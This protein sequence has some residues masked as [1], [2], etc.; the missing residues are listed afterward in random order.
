MAVFSRDGRRIVTAGRDYT[1]RVWDAGTGE[2]IASLE[3]HDGLVACANFSPDGELVVTASEDGKAMV[4]DAGSGKLL[5]VL[6][7]HLSDVRWAEFS[8]DGTL[9][10]TASEDCTARIWDVHPETR[11]P[12]EIAELVSRWV[13]WRLEGEQL[14][15][16]TLAPEAPQGEGASDAAQ[17]SLP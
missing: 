8:P 17:P 1:A 11:S 7:G 6:S 2:P 12:A 4:W 16:V 13:P 5:T 15:P 3:G 9:I 14:V 10:L